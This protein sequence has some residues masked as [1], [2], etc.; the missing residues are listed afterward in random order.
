MGDYLDNE[1]DNGVLWVIVGGIAMFEDTALWDCPVR[2]A[3]GRGSGY[4][5]CDCIVNGGG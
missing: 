4:G 1:Y 3:W 5:L 2:T